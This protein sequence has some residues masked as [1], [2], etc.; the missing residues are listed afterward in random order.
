MNIELEKSYRLLRFLNAPK[1][2]W[3]KVFFAWCSSAYLTFLRLPKA[4]RA[5]TH[6]LA[7]EENGIKIAVRRL[8]WA[9]HVSWLPLK[10]R[11]DYF[12]DVSECLGRDASTALVEWLK[13][14]RH[15]S[16]VERNVWCADLASGVINKAFES[17]LEFTLE[18]GDALFEYDRMFQDSVNNAAQELDQLMSQRIDV[19]NPIRFK[20]LKDSFD[21]RH[22]YSA[23][24]D[25]KTLMQSLGWQWF[26][27]SG[28][29][30]GAVRE[31]DFL[32][33]D[34]DLDLG[35]LYEE[36]DI[37]ALTEAVSKSS[38]WSIKSSSQ[39][40]YRTAHEGEVRYH[41]MAKPILVKLKHETGL[42]VD[43]FVHVREEE[44]LWHGSAIHRWDNLDF[45]VSEYTLGDE[46]VLGPDNA[47]RY[48]TENYG[49]WRVP[50]KKFDCSIDPPNISYSNT[51]KSISYLLKVSYR[52]L[53]N[54]DKGQAQRY[55]DSMIENGVL[56]R[57]N[58]TLVYK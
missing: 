54:G 50:V 40:L 49:E 56:E 45:G 36:F 9:T 29:F 24:K 32:G 41:R 10:L 53:L 33:H 25:S 55:I 28:T 22:A 1:P 30:L 19:D 11:S 17:E 31:G 5:D 12:F 26:V 51:A 46:A 14:N 38:H 20:K 52:F 44:L 3:F 2:K 23:L 13:N 7:F 42:V 21:K 39:C 57:C 47:D 15:V 16:G 58:G 6:A 37:D 35:V 43:V 4:Y 34:Y 48:L 27:I 8:I 18:P